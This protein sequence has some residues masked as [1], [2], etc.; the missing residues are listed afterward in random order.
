MK[1]SSKALCFFTALLV[2]CILLSGCVLS[3]LLVSFEDDY[4]LLDEE[5]EI[6]AIE[7]GKI[8]LE[9]EKDFY[10]D[11]LCDIS[12]I[13]G[14][15]KDF[16]E[17][18]AEPLL[19]DPRAPRDNEFAFKITYNDSDFEIIHYYGQAR[20]YDDHLYWYSG[21]ETF[22]KDE[23]NAFLNNYKSTSR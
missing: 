23:F 6:S 3:T 20:Y 9:N 1:K 22:D 12:D 14:F 11:K 7:I 16:R 8:N 4:E 21:D 10:F 19:S 2:A 18:K 17:L 15:I 5:S 13:D